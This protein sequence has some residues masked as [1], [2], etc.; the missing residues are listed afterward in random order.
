MRLIWRAATSA[1]A[2]A[3]D[4]DV[5]ADFKGMLPGSSSV[6]AGE[7]ICEAR[8]ASCHGTFGGFNEVFS[9]LV[10]GTAPR[11]IETGRVE[12]IAKRGF[13]QR[14]TLMKV[15]K[16]STP[17]L[18]INRATPCKEP[19]SLSTDEVYAAQEELPGGRPRGVRDPGP[20]TQ[21]ARQHGRPGA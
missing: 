15:S 19:R 20:C 6:Q 7:G 12:I 9:A 14:T 21:H 3:W 18:C 4:T 2:R 10:G 13:P 8:C 17:W 16:V 5:R 1:E 11:D